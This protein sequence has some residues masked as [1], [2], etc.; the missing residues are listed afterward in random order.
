MEK[1]Q[2]KEEAAARGIR[3]GVCFQKG[4]TLINNDGEN[5]YTYYAPQNTGPAQRTAIGQLSDGSVI[6]IVTD[7]RSSQSLGATHDDMINVMA[8][9]GAVTAG[10]LDGGSSSLMYYRNYWDI[11]GID[12]QSLDTY[13]RMG[14][15]N[16][17]KAFTYPRLMPTYFLVRPEQ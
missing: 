10:L 16:R 6:L 8:S 9:Y 17:Y 3:D 13:Q 5:V 1:A 12:R 7:G 4:N 15:V 2:T 11:L 14:I